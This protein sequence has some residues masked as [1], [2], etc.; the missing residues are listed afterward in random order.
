MKSQL[1]HQTLISGLAAGT[2]LFVVACAALASLPLRERVATQEVE[3]PAIV[4]Q[5][6]AE[7]E[8]LSVMLFLHRSGTGFLPTAGVGQ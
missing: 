1:A 2:A 4:V 7:S 5:N 6:K 8:D 3:A